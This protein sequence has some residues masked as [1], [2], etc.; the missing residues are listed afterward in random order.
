MGITHFYY[1][2]FYVFQQVFF[3]K[4]VNK[5]YRMILLVLDK[6]SHRQNFLNSGI[7]LMFEDFFCKFV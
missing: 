7:F 6:K 2:N 5:F 3:G 1:T 4:A